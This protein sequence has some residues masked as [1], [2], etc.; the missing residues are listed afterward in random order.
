MTDSL[1][2]CFPSPICQG[3][4]LPAQPYLSIPFIPRGNSSYMKSALEH[5]K[6]D[7]VLNIHASTDPVGTAINKRNIMYLSHNMTML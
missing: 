3:G 5:Q 7:L 2:L 4:P 6:V 1:T